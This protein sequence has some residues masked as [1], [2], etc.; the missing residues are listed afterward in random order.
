[1]NERGT[2]CSITISLYTYAHFLY[3]YAKTQQLLCS[4]PCTKLSELVHFPEMLVHDR[5]ETLFALPSLR[6]SFHYLFNFE[7]LVGSN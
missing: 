6:F 1:M 3:V 2:L 5:P 7:F 4:V